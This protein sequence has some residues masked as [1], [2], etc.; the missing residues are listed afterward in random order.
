MI[1]PYDQECQTCLA[2]SFKGTPRPDWRHSCRLSSMDALLT[3]R[4]EHKCHFLIFHIMLPTW[5]PYH[6]PVWMLPLII[7]NHSSNIHYSILIVQYSLSNI[8]CPKSVQFFLCSVH[9]PMCVSL[10]PTSDSKE[11]THQ[12]IGNGTTNVILD[13]CFFL[14]ITDSILF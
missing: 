8:Y 13:C 7:Q 6:Y 1:K 9:V 11:P 3:S 14:F 5:P 2:T 12:L 10:P 4:C